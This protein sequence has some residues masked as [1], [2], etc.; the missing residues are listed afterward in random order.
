MAINF[1]TS[2]DTLFKPT[3][4]QSTNNPAVAHSQHHRDMATAIEKI[5]QRIGITNTTD[6]NSLEYGRKTCSIFQRNGNALGVGINPMDGYASARHL[7]IGTT[8]GDSGMSFFSSSTS[9]TRLIFANE[10]NN[11]AANLRFSHSNSRFE[12]F[13]GSDRPVIFDNNE[14]FLYVA[15]LGLKKIEAGA[16]NSAGTGYRALRVAN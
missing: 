2:L 16:A 10:T 1:P 3:A 4:G 8:A 11:A 9:A 7:V 14:V 13:I 15:G 6:V 12:F 5:Q